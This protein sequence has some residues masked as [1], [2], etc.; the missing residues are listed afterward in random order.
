MSSKYFDAESRYGVDAFA[1]SPAIGVD[2]N[3]TNAFSIK[4]RLSAGLDHHRLLLTPV[5][6]VNHYGDIEISRI[7]Q[8][9]VEHEK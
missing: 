6:A 7:R 9:M 5:H 1:E 3:Q 2:R 4:A 8:I